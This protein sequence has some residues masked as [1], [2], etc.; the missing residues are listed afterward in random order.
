MRN[1][2]W[3]FLLSLVFIVPGIGSRSDAQAQSIAPCPDCARQQPCLLCDWIARCCIY[4]AT[5]TQNRCATLETQGWTIYDAARSPCWVY[6]EANGNENCNGT[7]CR[8]EDPCANGG[9]TPGHAPMG[10]PGCAEATADECGCCLTYSPIAL[11]LNGDGIRMTN[12]TGG[13]LFDVN[14]LGRVMWVGWPVG[15]D[16]GWLVLD[17]NKNGAIDDGSEL[18]GNATRLRTGSIAK[19]GY[20]ALAELDTNGDLI[21]D[22]QDQRFSDLYIWL[23]GDGNGSVSEGE[24]RPLASTKI[25]GMSIVPKESQRRD[26]YG[27]RFRLRAAVF[28][29]DGSHQRYSYDVWPAVEPLTGVTMPSR[30]C[31]KSGVQ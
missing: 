10:S 30:T 15:R 6:R 3:I 1:I 29:I 31:S 23:D 8:S 20:E 14:G 4:E 21:V 16:D 2:R 25:T 11:D 17:R 7:S 5:P 28:T 19:D 18:F 9:C 13:A 12:A 26:S 22:R 27:N 24:L